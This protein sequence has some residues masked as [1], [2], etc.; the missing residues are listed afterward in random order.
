[1]SDSEY[2]FQFP[3]RYTDGRSKEGCYKH[4]SHTDHKGV[5]ALSSSWLELR[6]PATTINIR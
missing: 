6:H 2:S 5:L 3:V 4:K 1:M